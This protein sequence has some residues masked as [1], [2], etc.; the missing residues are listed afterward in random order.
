[1]LWETVGDH[2]YEINTFESRDVKRFGLKKVIVNGFWIAYVPSKS[3]YST[4]TILR[5]FR[6]QNP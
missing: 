4:A 1:M 3:V 2:I 6:R 5:H